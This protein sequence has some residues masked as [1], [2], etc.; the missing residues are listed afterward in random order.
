MK[1]INLVVDLKPAALRKRIRSQSFEDCMSSRESEFVQS[2]C[3]SRETRQDQ[4][5][6]DAELQLITNFGKRL[7]VKITERDVSFVFFLNFPTFYVTVAA[8]MEKSISSRDIIQPVTFE[9]QYVLSEL[10]W[11]MF[12][13]P[14]PY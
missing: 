1:G 3:S 5:E 9:F 10:G 14:N 13:N 2:S 12:F 8:A 6:I 4:E 11:S 7:V